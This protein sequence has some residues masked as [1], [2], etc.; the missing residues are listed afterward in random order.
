MNAIACRAIHSFDEPP[1]VVVML[2]I[3]GGGSRKPYL[4]TIHS[5]LF[6]IH[7]NTPPYRRPFETCGD[8]HGM[9]ARRRHTSEQPAKPALSES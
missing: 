3:T 2:C 4:F 7:R 9:C 5:S 8:C 1:A 6:T